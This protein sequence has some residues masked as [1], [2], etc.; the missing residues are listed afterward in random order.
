MS[1]SAHTERLSAGSLPRPC[2]SSHTATL[3]A[4]IS[5]VATAGLCVGLSSWSET[6]AATV[7]V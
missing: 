3:S 6:M 4:M 7:P 5:T 2:T 1:P